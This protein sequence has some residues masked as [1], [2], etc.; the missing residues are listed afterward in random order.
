MTCFGPFE[1]LSLTLVPCGSDVPGAGLWETTWPC[2]A[3][4]STNDGFGLNPAALSFA[5]ASWMLR[6]TTLGTAAIFGPLE[7]FTRTFVP[8]GTDCPPAG[9]VAV[10]MIRRLAGHDV[11]HRLQSGIHEV[12]LRL[13]P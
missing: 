11:L 9:S 13:C 4:L 12:G 2:G 7:T 3:V 1:T 5:V 10:T 6:P 8:F